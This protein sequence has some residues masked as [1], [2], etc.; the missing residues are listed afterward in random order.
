MASRGSTRGSTTQATSALARWGFAASVFGLGALVTLAVFFTTRGRER[1]ARAI[2]LER[3]A[4]DVTR[5]AQASFDVP[6]EVLRSV[7]AL[8]EASEEV[9]RAEFRAFVSGALARYPW[10]Y[11][12]EW[13]PRVPGDQRAQ[14]EARAVA[15]G[16]VGYHFKQDA[17]SGPPEPAD[18]RPEYFPLYYMEPPNPIAI[19]LEETALPARKLAL[20]RAR[21]RNA[22]IMSSRL[23][24]VQDQPGVASVIAF[25]PVYRR[26]EIPATVEARRES[27]RGLS[28]AVFRIAP[29]LDKAL[30]SFDLARLDVALLDVDD[31]PPTI[32]YESRAGAAAEG[33][34]ARDDNVIQ[35]AGRRW[36]VRV[37]DR[38]GWAAS[39]GLAGWPHL[40]IGLIASA[41]AAAFAYAFQ[42][43]T[44]L[45]RQVHA[46]RRLG[47][48]TL[49]ALLGRGGMGTVYRAHH[50]LLRRPTAIKLLDRADEVSLARFESEA[51]LTSA[52]THPNTVVVYDYGRSPDG[53]FYYAMEY[54][55]GITLQE[56]VDH[57]G[58][59]PPRRVV[60]IL[61]QVLGAL[62]EAHRIGLVHRD[63]K[64]ANIMLCRRGNI[65]D[66]VKVLDFGLAKDLS[67]DARH[68][69]SRS[70][71]FVGTP[72]YLAPEVA[73]REP[74]DGRTDLYGVGAVAYFLL[75]GK[76][77]FE[78]ANA[79]EVCAHHLSSAPEPPSER[80]GAPLPAGLE[81][82]VLRCLAKDAADRPASAEEL[83]AALHA[84]GLEPWTA[85]EARRWWADAGRRVE[86]PAAQELGATGG[87]EDTLEI[88]LHG[89]MPEPRKL[90]TR[91]AP[92]PPA[93]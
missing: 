16:L 8:F 13:I 47:Q 59:Q 26:G 17:P 85:E 69:L 36:A 60:H 49:V 11:A 46:V 28:A 25:H 41:L 54:I 52:L 50:A 70:S 93:P 72:L 68:D 31:D 55:D 27:L 21:D 42:Q 77:V 33:A 87:H 75:T 58:P 4:A 91:R 5:A 82:L 32:L 53:V 56:L 43:A 71:I 14:Y 39:A 15:D 92:F 38:G 76:P 18:E 6:L 2:E 57:D 84:L 65:D 62:G 40:A 64:P 23:K 79:V 30:E 34:R 89:V 45:E 51:Q 7:P 3:R 83:A 67:A 88:A 1:S 80:L 44:R 12:V 66:F 63:V 22:T 24:L 35:I 86:R 90:K 74:I 29:V 81:A 10:L 9:T 19:G 61:A 73:R 48:Y 78:G 20:E 37:T